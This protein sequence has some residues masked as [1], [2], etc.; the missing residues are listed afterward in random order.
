ML[1]ESDAASVLKMEKKNAVMSVYT[2]EPETPHDG[3]QGVTFVCQSKQKARAVI[4]SGSGRQIRTCLNLPNAL[5]F[6][7]NGLK[8]RMEKG[9]IV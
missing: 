9:M 1:A 7:S 2:L 6:L 8:I 5:S 4:G 3:Y